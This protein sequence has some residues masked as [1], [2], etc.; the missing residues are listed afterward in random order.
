MCSYCK[1]YIIEQIIGAICEVDK[2]NDVSLILWSISQISV[3][4]GLGGTTGGT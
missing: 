2:I 4:G 1:Q 3:L